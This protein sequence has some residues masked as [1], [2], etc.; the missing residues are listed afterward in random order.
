MLTWTSCSG[1]GRSSRRQNSHPQL[2]QAVD[3]GDELIARFGCADPGRRAGHDE[4]PSLER[5]VLRKKRD[6]FGH[7]PDH[8]VD[9]RVLAKFSVYL[10]PQLALLRVPDLRSG[11]DRSDRS[12][13]VEIL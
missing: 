4:V 11:A 10:E 3:S 1:L 5:V 13:L 8:L 7:A 6:L 2:T 12:G 9:V